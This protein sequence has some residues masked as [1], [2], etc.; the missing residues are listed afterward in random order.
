MIDEKKI[1]KALNKAVKD[2]LL[3]MV[4]VNGEWCYVKN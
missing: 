1:Q 3:K 4:L 2:G